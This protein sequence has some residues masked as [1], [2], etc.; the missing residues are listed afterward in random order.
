MGRRRLAGI[1]EVNIAALK[2]VYLRRTGLPEWKGR[3]GLVWVC[4]PRMLADSEK[5]GCWV[6]TSIMLVCAVLMSL[7]VGVLVAYWVCTAM[8]QVFRI[9]ARQVQARRAVRG[10]VQVV[11]G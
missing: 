9:H 2:C 11:R 7:A 3:L 1:L 5:R 8:F 6:T 10:A 4:E